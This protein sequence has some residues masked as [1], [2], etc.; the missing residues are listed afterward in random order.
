MAFC[1]MCGTPIPDGT[2]RCDNCAAAENG[3]AAN[4][5]PN[6]SVNA[7]PAAGSVDFNKYVDQIKGTGINFVGLFAQIFNILALCLPIL[8]NTHIW[9][10]G[11]NVGGEWYLIPIAVIF[12]I[13]ASIIGTLLKND[14][15]IKI[16]SIVKLVCILI[17]WFPCT[18]FTVGFYLWLVGVVLGLV[19]TLAMKLINKYM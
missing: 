12:V 7:A 5:A 13:L 2:T 18:R 16:A 19:S 1:E 14:K 6:A 3:A 17:V 10:F 4:T 15:A 9:E 11:D 8:K